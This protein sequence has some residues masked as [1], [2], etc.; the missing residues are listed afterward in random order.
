V[1]EHALYVC[2]SCRDEW[3]KALPPLWTAFDMW[4]ECCERLA[5]LVEPVPTLEEELA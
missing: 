2:P 4:P 3:T 1:I 5:L